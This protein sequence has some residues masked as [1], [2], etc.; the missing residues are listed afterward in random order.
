M[1]FDYS[2][3]FP[4]VVAGLAV[5][6]IYR[7][8]RRSFGRQRIRPGRMRLRMIL[9]TLVGC[10][11]MPL[12][13]QSSQFLLAEIVGAAA[14]AALAVWGAQRTR[15]QALGGQLY[16]VPH[17]YT[18]IAVSLL[19]V[20]RLVYRLVE[21]YSM[22]RSIPS[23]MI[24]DPLS[25]PVMARSPLTIGLLFAVVGYYVCYFSVILW[26]SK[27]IRPEELEVDATSTAV[28]P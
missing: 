17:T 16:Y 2:R 21:W 10:S 5:L 7:R 22:K 9:L 8:F 11:L 18:G 12:A 14:G 4:Y 3:I 27:R 1:P 24:G 25:S 15:Y 20:G 28:A 19:L 26:R 13:L 6:L 23:G